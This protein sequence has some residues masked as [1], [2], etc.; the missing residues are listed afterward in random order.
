MRV[1][2]ACALLL[3]L[4]LSQEA[5]AEPIRFEILPGATL[6]FEGQTPTPLS[7]ALELE[8]RSIPT[9]PPV[10]PIACPFQLGDVTFDVT[11]LE[12][13]AG[14]LALSGQ[15]PFEAVP[16][17]SSGAFELAR[18]VTLGD[19]GL[20][21]S[22]PPERAVRLGYGFPVDLAASF[23]EFD[24]YRFWLLE[25]EMGGTS[26]W[27]GSD[28][29]PGQ[30][31]IQARLTENLWDFSPLGLQGQSVV[32]SAELVLTAVRVPEPSLALLEAAAV[33][34]LARFRRWRPSRRDDS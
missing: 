24:R 15:G 4:A 34:V 8:C 28:P 21:S 29:L 19:V 32:Q 25:E 22:P 7:G 14:E 33:A 12:L 20:L 3:L 11:S 13:V 31:A 1:S 6:T 5:G 17:S 2:L 27:S 23:P 18:E 9:L 10:I 26:S 16:Y 30:L